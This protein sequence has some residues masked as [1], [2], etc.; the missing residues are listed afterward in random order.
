MFHTKECYT[1]PRIFL[2]LG[3]M[4]GEV[5]T[6]R[7]YRLEKDEPKVVK[8]LPILVWLEL[9]PGIPLPWRPKRLLAHR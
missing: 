4:G 8:L 2:R 5:K 9:A 3:Q 1:R 6:G 7:S